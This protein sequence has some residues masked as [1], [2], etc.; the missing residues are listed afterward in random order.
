MLKEIFSKNRDI[1]VNTDIDGFLCGLFLQKYFDCRIVGF[2][3]SKSKIWTIPEIQSIYDPVYIDLFVVN[4][5][6][7]C[8]EQHII[9]KDDVHLNKIISWGTKINPNLVRG[10]TFEGDYSHKYPFGT[11]H[12]LLALMEYEGIIVDFPDLRKIVTFPS[13][14]ISTTLGHII[15]RADD[16]LY[17]TLSAYR[18][19]ALDWWKFLDGGRNLTSV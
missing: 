15:L 11:I 19:N 18:D 12:F 14:G 8:I 5:F 6:V 3:N 10:R 17:S 13:S 1:I 9:A 7:I 4:P 16:A 2:S